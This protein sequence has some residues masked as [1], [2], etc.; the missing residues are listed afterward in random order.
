MT[1]NFLD[2]TFRLA[3]FGAAL[4]LATTV[5]GLL[6]PSSQLPED[7]P[8]DFLLHAMG[9]GV[10]TL[11]AVFAARN[12]RGLINAVTIITL[13]ALASEAAQALVPGRTVSALDFVADL[14][15]IALGACLGRMAQLLVFAIADVPRGQS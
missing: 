1:R 5:V 2:L 4:S 10:P 15:G 6:T 3:R 11:L 7:L 13:V 9:F 14:L 12:G 8:P